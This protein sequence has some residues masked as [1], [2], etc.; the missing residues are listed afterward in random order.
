MKAKI[1][2]KNAEVIKVFSSFVAIKLVDGTNNLK[3]TG[4]SLGILISLLGIC[5][6]AFYLLMTK[7]N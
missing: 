4:L 5:L 3:I 1:N 7:K 6:L 2:N